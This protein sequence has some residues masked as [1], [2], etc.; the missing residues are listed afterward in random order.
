MSSESIA[1]EDKII[2]MVTIELVLTIPNKMAI[3]NVIGRERKCCGSFKTYAALGK[4]SNPAVIHHTG[5][6]TLSHKNN[7]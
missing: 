3:T 7:P 1:N 6:R 2:V 5:R 4:L